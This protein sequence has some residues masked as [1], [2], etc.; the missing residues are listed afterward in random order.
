MVHSDALWYDILTCTEI[1]ESN[2]TKF[3]GFLRDLCSMNFRE[4]AP[5]PLVNYLLLFISASDILM[6][7]ALFLDCTKTQNVCVGMN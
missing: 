7:I 5:D 3:W 2:E 6:I 4:N 1:F